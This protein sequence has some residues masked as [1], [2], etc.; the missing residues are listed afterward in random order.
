L[1]PGADAKRWQAGWGIAPPMAGTVV[2]G[3]LF[4]RLGMKP[5]AV[6]VFN[7]RRDGNLSYWALARFGGGVPGLLVAVSLENLAGGNGGKRCSW[8]C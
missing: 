1:P 6:A 5:L 7:C 4:A 3:V 8:P 2:G